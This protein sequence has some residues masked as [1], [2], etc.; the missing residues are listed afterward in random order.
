MVKFLLN[1]HGIRQAYQL[2]LLH[3]PRAA[4]I[5]PD[6]LQNLRQVTGNAFAT[7]GERPEIGGFSEK[8]LGY[9]GYRLEMRY[10]W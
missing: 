2:F 5:W 6:Q 10:D 4:E 3:D 7:Q 9:N 8:N 1:P